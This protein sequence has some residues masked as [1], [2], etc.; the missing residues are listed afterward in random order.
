MMSRL[1]A[2]CGRLSAERIEGG[3][4]YGKMAKEQSIFMGYL[5][6][7]SSPA[8]CGAR[9]SVRAARAAVF[10]ERGGRKHDTSHGHFQFD[11]IGVF[12]I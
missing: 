1:C 10:G 7:H 5:N 8:T 6:F 3:E 4:S 12:A 11:G 9:S 2:R